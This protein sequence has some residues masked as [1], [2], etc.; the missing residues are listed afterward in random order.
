MPWDDF[1]CAVGVAA[2]FCVD[3][4]S[5]IIRKKGFNHQWG[6][7]LKLLKDIQALVWPVGMMQVYRQKRANNAVISL[8]ALLYNTAGYQ[9]TDA[10]DKVY[11]ILGLVNDDPDINDTITPAYDISTDLLYIKVARYAIEHR[12]TLAILE[13][14]YNK[15]DRCCKNGVLCME[16]WVPDFTDRADGWTIDRSPVM[17]EVRDMLN[18]YIGILEGEFPGST[19]SKS[20]SQAGTA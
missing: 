7:R 10:R 11:A 1:H 5:L 8:E 9:A 2:V 13:H 20:Q 12:A 6:Q 14:G 19:I 3:E 17:P 16:S 18:I 15:S 4:A